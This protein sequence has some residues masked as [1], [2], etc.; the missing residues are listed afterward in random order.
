M[1]GRGHEARNSSLE[2]KGNGSKWGDSQ[3][4]TDYLSSWTS[5]KHFHHVLLPLQPFLITNMESV[6]PFQFE[7]E[8][9][10]Q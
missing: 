7:I 3:V 4:C 10:K 9:E 2:L 6:N 1:A 5:S 8:V